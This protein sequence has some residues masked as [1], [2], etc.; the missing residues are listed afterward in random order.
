MFYNPLIPELEHLLYRSCL[1]EH[2]NKFLGKLRLLP[3]LPQARSRGL[4]RQSLTAIQDGSFELSGN[5]C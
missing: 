4:D 2:H 1:T 3:P 5:L